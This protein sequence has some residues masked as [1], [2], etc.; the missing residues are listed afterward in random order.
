MVGVNYWCE[1]EY[2]LVP[3]RYARS[4]LVTNNTLACLVAY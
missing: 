2:N 4:C 1:E 3:D